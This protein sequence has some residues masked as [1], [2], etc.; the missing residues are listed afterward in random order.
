MNIRVNPAGFETEHLAA[1]NRSFP[2]WG[3]ERRLRWCFGRS[4]DLVVAELDGVAVAGTGISYRRMRA[5]HGGG[6][7]VGIFTAA[8]SFPVRAERGLYLRVMT[9]ATRL[10]GER[11]G[12]LALGFMPQDKS[13]GHQLLRT[14]AM[15][16]ATA[17]VMTPAD[18]DISLSDTWESCSDSPELRAVLFER[19]GQ[20]ARDGLSFVYSDAGDFAGQFLERPHPVQALVNNC[21]DYLLVERTSRALNLLAAL[22]AGGGRASGALLREAAALAARE[23]RPLFAYAAN[24]GAIAEAAAA[25][26]VTRPGF[27]TVTVASHQ[28]L[29]AALDPGGQRTDSRSAET[30]CHA[31]LTALHVENGDRM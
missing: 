7:L 2:G 6:M 9:E 20:R 18:V 28:S 11:G 23:G 16:V 3:D 25:G 19:A 1:L 8:W 17:Y 15:A 29:S 24:A 26:L 31:A 30:L 10:I 5:P 27:M 14:G 21:G 13:S 12:A 22:P 4:S